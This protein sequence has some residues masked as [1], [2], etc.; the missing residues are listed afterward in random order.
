MSGSDAARNADRSRPVRLLIATARMTPL[1]GGIETHVR[2]VSR[3]LV[4]RGFDVTVVTTDRTGTL[5][6]DEDLDGVRIHR[7]PASPSDG[8][9]YWSPGLLRYVNRSSWDLVH[10]QGIHT[11]VPPAAMFAAAVRGTPFV[12]TFHTGGHASLLRQRLRAA[13]WVSLVPLLRKASRLI[14][15]SRFEADLFR[16]LPGIDPRCV[17]VIPNG[18]EPLPLVVGG[19]VVDPD[20]VVAVGRL[21]RYKGHQHLIAAMPHLARR[22]P[23][24][25]LKIVGT[26]PFEDELRKLAV[27]FGVGDRVSISSIAPD[28]RGA[29]ARLVAGAGVVALMSEYEAHPIAVLEAVALGRR[30]VGT[31][32]AGLGELAEDGLIRGVPADITPQGLSTVL[33]EELDAPP[34]ESVSLPTWDDCTDRLAAVYRAALDRTRCGS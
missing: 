34:R 31:D 23:G 12:V 17:E 18:A 16:A 4:S 2:E 29:M 27:D 13:Q 8:D 7:T 9:L 24:A 28:D 3:R 22:R 1:T 19:T 33:D 6:V 21:E 15:V 26:G 5:P 10:V 32:L 11:L 30:V 14:G 20:S 25:Q